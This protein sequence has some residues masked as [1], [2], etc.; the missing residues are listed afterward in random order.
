MRAA[1][2]GEDL[3]GRLQRPADIGTIEQ[4]PIHPISGSSSSYPKIGSIAPGNAHSK[5]EYVAADAYREPLAMAD[6][7][8]QYIYFY[9]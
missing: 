7:P 6:K 5:N 8:F 2:T 3:P 4:G 9:D 1:A